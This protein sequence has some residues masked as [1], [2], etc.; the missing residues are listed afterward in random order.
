MS[1]SCIFCKIIAKEIPST[2]I[3]DNDEL[4]VIKDINPKAPIHYL[5]IPKKHVADITYFEKQDELLA[6]K[7]VLMA[8]QL[9]QALPGSKAFRLIVNNGADAGQCVFHVHFHFL[10]GKKMADF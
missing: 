7:M 3:A 4:V 5:I 9:A 2:I 6:G 1:S 8:Q 10:A